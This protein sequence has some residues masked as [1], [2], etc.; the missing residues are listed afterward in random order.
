MRES[1]RYLLGLLGD[2][3]SIGLA[4]GGSVFAGIITGWLLDERLFHGR[5][6]PYLTVI[7]AGFG[8]AGGIRN[9]F[10]MT[11]RRLREKGNHDKA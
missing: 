8:I 6:S 3:L 4:V 9:I 2:F 10:L 1:L 11:R 7:C 5:T